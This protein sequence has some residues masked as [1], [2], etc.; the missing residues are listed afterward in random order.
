MTKDEFYTLT[1][2]FKR[3]HTELEYMKNRLELLKSKRGIKAS[4][5]SEVKG[6]GTGSME[7]ATVDIVDLEEKIKVI[8]EKHDKKEQVLYQI[9]NKVKDPTLKYLLIYR[10][11]DC[12]DWEDVASNINYSF[13]YTAYRLKADAINEVL[14]NN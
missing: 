9:F 4:V 1:E 7:N 13:K 2:D 12:M 6:N 14:K 10:Y 3:E 11:I 5:Q 8:K